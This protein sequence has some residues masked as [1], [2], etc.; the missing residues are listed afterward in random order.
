MN[1]ST[2][3]HK[4]PLSAQKPLNANLTRLLRA[5]KATD[6]IKSVTNTEL[7]M[8]SGVSRMYINRNTDSITEYYKQIVLHEKS[9]IDYLRNRSL[10]YYLSKTTTPKEALGAVCGWLLKFQY[11]KLGHIRKVNNII[12]VGQDVVEVMRLI[13]SRK[14]KK[15]V[16][17][18]S[19][20]GAGHRLLYNPK[21]VW[22]GLFT[23]T[24][25]Y[26]NG[27]Q[28]N[29]WS[30]KPFALNLLTEIVAITLKRITK[31]TTLIATNQPPFTTLHL[32]A[33]LREPYTISM[34]RSVTEKGVVDKVIKT[35]IAT[36]SYFEC[37]APT[38]FEVPI[39]LLINFTLTS[40][41]NILT[42][43]I[44]VI[45]KSLIVS[46]RHTSTRNPNFGRHYNVFT[47]IKSIER[48]QLGYINYDMSAAMQTISLQLIQATKD[49]YP[50]LTRY[51]KDKQFKRQFRDAIANDIGISV[52]Q[53]K[54]RLTSFA[55]GGKKDIERHES[56]QAFYD[57]SVQMRKKVMQLVDDDL[58]AIATKQS[59]KAPSELSDI[60]K[61][62]AEASRYFFVWTYY[63]RL[64][65]KAMLT[66]LT[67]GIEVHDAVYSKMD[68]STDDIEAA[69]F[70]STGFK[71]NID[72][73]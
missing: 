43:T 72:K 7:A 31:P 14:D 6:G 69:I 39:A 34:P 11:G 64:I 71:I 49:D 19:Q 46:A 58:L 73:E 24:L 68:V 16:A 53:V 42:V 65:R 45:D 2:S 33:Y 37:K 47:R 8:M 20:V 27:N 4:K 35:F 59:R 9:D 66:V 26:N 18:Y 63:E 15:K 3:D 1:C 22:D 48:S 54:K 21:P 52:T 13:T 70:E 57:E 5:L 28:Q 10:A 32:L 60:E 44:G 51:S 12:Q 62:R 55:N 41:L 29:L 61:D 67:D 38:V 56:Y 23:R 36:H 30:M 17:I 25:K 40:I 50:L